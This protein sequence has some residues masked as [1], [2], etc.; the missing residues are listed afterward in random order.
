MSRLKVSDLGVARAGRIVLAAVELMVEPGEVVGLLGPNGAGKTSLL[1]ALARLDRPAG[2]RIML[3]GRPLDSF[4]RAELA[5][6]L[7]FLPQP[8]ETAW[9]IT[10][11]NLVGLGRLPFQPALGRPTE[12]DREATEHAISACG[13]DAFRDRPVTMLSAGEASRAFLARALAGRPRLLL[14]DE[15]TANLDPAHQITAMT[16]LREVAKEG[17]SVVMAQHDL[18]LAARYCDRLI[19]LGGGRV[20]AQ[21]RPE[22]VLTSDNLAAVF[23]IRGR[24]SEGGGEGFFVIPW[25]LVS[26]PGADDI[27]SP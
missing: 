2:G 10:V 7:A 11:E 18:P 5:R 20:V 17:G 1:R 23:G 16:V 6:L 13:L 15:P 24:Y 25:S 14:A 8:P 12:V 19:L 3:E 21:G 9:P 22:E 4:G 27:G 26:G